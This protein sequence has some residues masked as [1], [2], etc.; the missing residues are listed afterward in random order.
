MAT[1]WCSLLVLL[2]PAMQVATMPQGAKDFGH[3]ILSPD[4]PMQSPATPLTSTQTPAPRTSPVVKRNVIFVPCRG[5]CMK[6]V[7]GTCM[8]DTQCLNA[9]NQRPTFKPR[10]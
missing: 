4:P 1:T 9:Q 3:Q 10:S 2:V 7:G 6:D 8:V 5:H